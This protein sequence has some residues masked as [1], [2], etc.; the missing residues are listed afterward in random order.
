MVGKRDTVFEMHTFPLTIHFSCSVLEIESCLNNRGSVV[1]IVPAFQ[2]F[3]EVFNQDS[4]ENIF[5]FV[6]QIH[7]KTFYF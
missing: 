6:N 2:F 3:G 7:M 5:E 1:G 4:K